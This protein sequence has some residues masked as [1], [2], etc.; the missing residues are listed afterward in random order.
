MTKT[1]G[2]LGG[3]V[4]NSIVFDDVGESV[5]LLYTGAA[6]EVINRCGVNGANGPTIS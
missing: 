2:N 5:T 3:T 4:A 1:D 6:W